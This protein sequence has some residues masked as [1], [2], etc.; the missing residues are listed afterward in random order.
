MARAQRRRRPWP[1]SAE[2][3][4]L[5][6]SPGDYSHLQ[7]AKPCLWYAGDRWRDG[8]L[9][10]VNRAA[11]ALVVGCHYGGELTSFRIRDGRNV[12]HLNPLAN[13]ANA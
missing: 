10:E 2:L 6:R 9:L 4:R 11:G 5:S 3:A 13:G 1:S 7:P 8:L 12:Q